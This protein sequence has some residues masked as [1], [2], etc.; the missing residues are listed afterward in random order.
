MTRLFC[1]YLA[2]SA[3]LTMTGCDWFKT[4]FLGQSSGVGQ[5]QVAHDSLV[6]MVATDSIQAAG[7]AD[8]L[9]QSQPAQ[10]ERQPVAADSVTLRYLVIVGSFKTWGNADRMLRL[11]HDEGYTT[12]QMVVFK[13][14][15]WG[16]SV[17]SHSE[18]HA[19]VQ[20]L[21]K[22]LPMDF[23]PEDAWVY[24]SDALLHISALPSFIGSLMPLPD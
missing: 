5:A 14:G 6:Q 7:A 8:S 21:N 13:S 19:A 20:A 11:L 17:S 23:C 16:I 2:A 10:L 22:I 4:T 24:D 1:I 15:F 3:A 18:V 12:A 9:S